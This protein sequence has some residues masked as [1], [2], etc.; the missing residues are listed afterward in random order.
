ML[1]Q[2]LLALLV[3]VLFLPFLPLLIWS[4][5]QGWYFPQ[6]LP[7]WTLQNWAELFAATSRVGQGFVQSFAIA[8]V[9]TVLSLLIGL[10]AGRA[11]GLMQFP[12]KE[13]LK[14]LILMPI[15]VSPLATLIG[16]QCNSEISALD[17]SR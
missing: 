9:T 17:R 11:I 8:T 1:R 15:I 5:A 10:P 3:V 13:V 2:T 14:L 6:L 12:G 16:I 7:Q 4:F